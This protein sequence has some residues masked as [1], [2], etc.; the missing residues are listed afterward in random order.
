M[1]GA[2]ASPPNSLP[3]YP[4][5]CAPFFRL[6]LCISLAEF[7]RTHTIGVPMPVLTDAGATEDYNNP[8]GGYYVEFDTDYDE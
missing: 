8:D 4:I 6:P 2:A 5:A 7:L 3:L 1:L